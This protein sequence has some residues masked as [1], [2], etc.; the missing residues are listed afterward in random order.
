MQAWHSRTA[1]C[2]HEEEGLAKHVHLG[3]CLLGVCRPVPRQVRRRLHPAAD[4][5]LSPI[6]NKTP[7]DPHPPPYNS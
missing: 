2:L 4:L 7:S 1:H 5:K 6:P 3:G